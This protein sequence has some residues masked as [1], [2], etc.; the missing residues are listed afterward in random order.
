MLDLY[1]TAWAHAAATF[2]ELDLDSPG[3][4]PWWGDDGDVTLHQIL[5]H[6]TTETYRHAGHADI[7]RE[8]IDGRAGRQAGRRQHG[9][10]RYDW[11]AYVAKVEQAARDGRRVSA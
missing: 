5:V 9:R 1:R 3:Q 7:V 11:P 4:V 6:M 10:G 8:A 2:A